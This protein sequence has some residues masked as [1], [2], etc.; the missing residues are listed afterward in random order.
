MFRV[1]G[2]G[3]AEGGFRAQR[4]AG[5]LQCGTEFKIKTGVEQFGLLLGQPF[6]LGEGGGSLRHPVLGLLCHPLDQ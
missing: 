5:L 1:E 6:N 2:D 4:L 3:P